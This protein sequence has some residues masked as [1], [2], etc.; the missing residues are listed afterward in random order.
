VLVKEPSYYKNL[1]MLLWLIMFF[2]MHIS[3]C[4]DS[5]AESDDEE[6]R[7]TKGLS[8]IQHATMHCFH[9]LHRDI[10]HRADVRGRKNEMPEWQKIVLGYKYNDEEMLQIFRVPRRLFHSLVRLLKNHPA[11]STNGKKQRKHFT[12][13]LHLLVLLKY[14]GTQGNA[15]SAFYVKNGLGIGKGS[16]VSYVMRAMD[17]VLSLFPDTVIWPDADERVEISNRVRAAYHFP[18]CVGFI[19]GTHLGLAFK[20]ELEGEE[21]FTRKQCYAISATLVCDD[22]KK[23]CYHNVSWPGSVHDQ[24]VYQN[25]VLNRN[26][27]DYFSDLEYSLGGSAYTSSPTMV[28]AYKKFGGQVTL[29]HGQIFFNDLL[30]RPR[31]MIEHTIGIWKGRFQLQRSRRCPG[32]HNRI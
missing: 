14:M 30:S 19:D 23:V 11:F 20:P 18:K 28:P 31:S 24:R 25:S 16:V 27:G 2:Q 10:T 7:T 22:N 5:D 29:A 8:A 9:Y 32:T 21:Y 4:D 26:P 6:I 15:C 12:A 1:E 3:L 13:E 17:A